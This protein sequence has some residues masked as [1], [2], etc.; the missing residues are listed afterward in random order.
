[1][2]F[3]FRE[4]TPF[5]SSNSAFNVDDEKEITKIELSDES[6]KVVLEKKGEEWLLNGKAETRK[7]SVLFIIRIIKEMR[8]KSPVSPEKFDAEIIRKGIGPVTVKV[9]GRSGKLRSYLVYKTSSN[10]YGNIMKRGERSKPFIV[11]VPGFEDN[12]GSAFIT[13]E[14][15][16]QPFTVFNL[17]PSEIAYLR[18]ENYSDS[19]SSF[20]ISH[21]GNNISLLDNE[22]VLAG[23]DTS[24]V[25]RYLTYFTW[26]PFEKWA[27]ELTQ[28]EKLDIE[29]G[30][31]LAKITVTGHSGN[32]TI[33][34]LWEKTGNSAG[35]ISKDTD[36]L[37]GK[38][39]HQS[40]IFILRYFDIDPILKRRSYFYPD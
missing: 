18:F 29:S 38:T 5:G 3:I 4:N 26:I 31:P 9:S 11:S 35:I 40:E 25:K 7:S 24:L 17:L 2:L 36:R 16:W 6:H 20:S 27:F 8:I 19:S 10:I 33:L 21:E 15:F 30:S 12:I 28:Q 23:W 22:K 34:T 13:N 14:L 39:N 32:N 1:M 37:W